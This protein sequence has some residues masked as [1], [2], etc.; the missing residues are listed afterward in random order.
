MSLSLFAV[1]QKFH[2]SVNLLSVESPI[3]MATVIGN[4]KWQMTF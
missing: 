4:C 3:L 1:S 2:N